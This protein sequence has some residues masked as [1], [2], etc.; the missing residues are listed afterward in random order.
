M[1]T[2]TIRNL[3]EAVKTKLR[4]RAASHG[5]S[6]EEE[7]RQILKQ[8]VLSPAG[9]KGLGNRI[10]HRFADLGGF[11]LALPERG[12]SRPPPDFSDTDD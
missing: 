11:D 10:H 7:A 1:T 9:E 12:A 3:D 2:L 8:A 4:L 5:C 6:M